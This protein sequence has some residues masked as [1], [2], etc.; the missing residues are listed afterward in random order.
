MPGAFD[1]PGFPFAVLPHIHQLKRGLLR[2]QLAGLLPVQLAGKVLD[3]DLRD[4]IDRQIRP[5]PSEEAVV[6][7]SSHGFQSHAS[8]ADA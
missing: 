7:I 4:L 3:A 1:V 2:V 6:E 5:H 8:Q